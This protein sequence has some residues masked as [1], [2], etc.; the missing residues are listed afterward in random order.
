MAD[1]A[2][3]IKAIGEN[4]SS[5][6][7]KLLVFR[8]ADEEYATEIT[9]TR[10]I[11]KHSEITKIPTA[12]KFIKGILNLRGQ[13]IVILDLRERFNL[14]AE[15]SEHI[16]ITDAGKSTFG[17]IVD[18]VTEIV[19]VEKDDIKDAPRI[20]SSK[21]HMDYIK[22]VAVLGERILI[23]L[24]LQKILNEEELSKVIETEGKN[25][26]P[27]EKLKKKE[28]SKEEMRR[29]IEKKLKK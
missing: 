13:I 29:I 5:E 12:P 19:K 23:I 17:I 18:K 15:E 4:L 25:E 7:L 28:I 14:P 8:L 3:K 6:T 24:D 21:I 1:A 11:I 9:Q 20:I 2:L 10:E 22:G 27:K 26:L 16:I